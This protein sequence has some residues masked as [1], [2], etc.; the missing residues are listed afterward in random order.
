MLQNTA[1]IAIKRGPRPALNL[2]PMTYLP[3]V[4]LVF[5]Y[6]FEI[7]IAFR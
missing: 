5:P 1:L 7:S 4:G 3:W 2:D 6:S